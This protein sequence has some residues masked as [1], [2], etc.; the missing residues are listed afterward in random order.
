MLSL[1]LRGGGLDLDAKRT[2]ECVDLQVAALQGCGWIGPASVALPET[3]EALTLGKLEP[4]ARCRSALE[5]RE[6]LR[7][8]GLGPTQPGVCDAPGPPATAC[9]LGTDPLAV[10]LRQDARSH[11]ECSGAC[12]RRTCVPAVAIGEACTFTAQCGS[13]NHCAGGRCAPGRWASEGQPCVVG[14][15]EPGTSCRGGTCARRNREGE[16]CR[17]DQECVGACLRPD[18]GADGTCGMRCGT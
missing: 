10:Y 16:R 17:A 13:G 8:R 5:C 18:G 9:E 15:C 3:C 4:G 6:G 7:C 14:A 2:A 12:V 1:A 11:P